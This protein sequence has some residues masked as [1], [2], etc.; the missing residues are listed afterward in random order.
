MYKPLSK[1]TEPRP[2]EAR[3]LSISHSEGLARLLGFG[4]EQI[5]DAAYPEHTMFDLPF[6]DAQFDAVVSDQVLE[7][8]EG[9]PQD[10]IDETFR[11]LKPGGLMYILDE[12]Y[13]GR[14]E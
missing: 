10:A 4:D 6:Q 2:A 12:D 8:L 5:T 13:A 7:H 1:L 11:I 14:P 9:D 3:V